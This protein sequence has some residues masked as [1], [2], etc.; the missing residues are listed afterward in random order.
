MRSVGRIR[1]EMLELLEQVGVVVEQRGNLLVYV[2]DGLVV[3]A[4]HV[5]DGEECLVD[6]V[7]GLEPGLDLVDEVD[8]LHEVDGLLLVAGGGA[9]DVLQ[10]DGEALGQEG[11]EA[12]DELRVAAEERLHP[13][14]DARRVDPGALEVAH[15]LEELVV[16]GAVV[17]E[18]V[19]DG[20]EVG[21]RVVG[22]QLL[23]RQ[24][25]RRR[26]R[27]HPRIGSTEEA[28]GVGAPCEDGRTD[29]RRGRSAPPPP[30]GSA[31]RKP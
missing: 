21:E 28:A 13:D 23:R 29:G 11:V 7:L 12:E 4:V 1:Q 31:R 27:G 9:V 20:L 30:A 3:H 17:V 24:R 8:G 25:G 10:L 5:E 14:D 26:R 2:L 15:D 19:L 18:L 16:L 6:V 22:G